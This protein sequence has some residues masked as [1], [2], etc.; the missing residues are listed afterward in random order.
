MKHLLAG[1]FGIFFYGIGIAQDI[2]VIPPTGS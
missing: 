2:H 1:F